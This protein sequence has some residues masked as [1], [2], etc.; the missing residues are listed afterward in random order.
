MEE[1]YEQI[2]FWG[3]RLR[4]YVEIC[5]LFTLGFFPLLVFLEYLLYVKIDDF[6]SMR[7]TI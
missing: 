7:S 1:K 4:I 6:R 2:A 5:K 3:L